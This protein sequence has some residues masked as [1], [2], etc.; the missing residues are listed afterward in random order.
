M[1]DSQPPP[2]SPGVPFP[3]PLLF[4]LGF[5]AAS[6]AHRER[7]A[8]LVPAD[9]G[10]PLDALGSALFFG[11][12]ALMF[13]GAATFYRAR[14][15]MYPTQR[16]TALVSGGPYRFTRNPMY[17]GLTIA[18][19]G[20]VATVNSVWPLAALPLV[21]VAVYA[22]VIRREERYLESEFG[23]AYRDY[24]RRVRRWL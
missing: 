15:A 10:I 1:T 4:V 7:P 19:L 12:L 3:P 8:T 13:W 24:R 2:T 22:F 11:G 17:L 6:V 23:D 5:G 9:A 20:G 14:T 21:L 18:Y 16:A